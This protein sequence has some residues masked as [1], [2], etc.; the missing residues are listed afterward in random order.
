MI[1]FKIIVNLFCTKMNTPIIHFK[2]FKI[3]MKFFILFII[4]EKGKIK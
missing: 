2:L 4:L 1:F 3:F